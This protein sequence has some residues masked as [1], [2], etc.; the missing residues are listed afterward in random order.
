MSKAI[1]AMT[2]SNSTSVK[3]FRFRMSLAS[4]EPSLKRIQRSNDRC[5]EHD[6]PEFGRRHFLIGKRRR[7]GIRFKEPKERSLRWD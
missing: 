1:I 6:Q 2:T 7:H 4:I 5:N 3:P